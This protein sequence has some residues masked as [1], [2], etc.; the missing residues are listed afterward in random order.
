LS[1]A[2]RII[3]RTGSVDS[4][5]SIGISPVVWRW[6]HT[7]R[8]SLSGNRSIADTVGHHEADSSSARTTRQTESTGWCNRT[9]LVATCATGMNKP[10]MYSTTPSATNAPNAMA[11]HF[12]TLIRYFLV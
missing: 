7:S 5:T 1:S 3:K 9:E 2:I 8:P 4:I 6:S 12:N 10:A 11:A